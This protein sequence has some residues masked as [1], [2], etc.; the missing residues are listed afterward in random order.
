MALV[1]ELDDL[2]AE[3]RSGNRRSLSRLLTLVEEG[4]NPP[5]ERGIGSSL[6][7][8]GPP[9]VGKSSLIGKMIDVWVGRGE[10]VAVLAVDPSSP[11]A[12]CSSW[13]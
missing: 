2:L 6:G 3:A 9:G 8:T 10:S 13:R 1:S 11:R 4:H 7:I 5:I 12:E